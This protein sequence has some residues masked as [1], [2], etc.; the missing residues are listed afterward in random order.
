M[1]M[2]AQMLKAQWRSSGIVAVVLAVLAFGAPLA[3]VFYG[4]NLARQ[5]TFTV[6]SWL[7]AAA[8]IGATVPVIALVAGVLLGMA[9]WSPDHLGGHVYALSL[10][11]PRWRYVL[12][13]FAT[14]L[15]FL[16]AP[17]AAL[18]AGAAIA[19][20]S[21]SLPEGL[22]AYPVQLTIRF[23]AAALVC[24]ALFFALSTAT[25]RVALVLLGLV[26]G[27]LLADVLLAA[28]A[29][30]PVAVETAFRLLTTWPGPLA[31]LMGRW[32]LFDV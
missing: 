19:T 11:L 7:S 25:R 18:A 10:P 23:A 32:A 24:Y 26:G 14:G 29:Q 31:I 20:A 4:A 13:R 16:A 12:L 3:T 1:S 9:V 21:V 5:S 6:A 17:V 15:P 28:F 22:H 30:Q 8:G 2:Y 27:F